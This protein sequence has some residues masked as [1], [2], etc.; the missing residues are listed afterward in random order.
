MLYSM[1]TNVIS[2]FVL[3]VSITLFGMRGLFLYSR[4]KTPLI[5]YFGLGAILGGISALMYSVPF[6]FTHVEST[7]KITTII[8]DFFYYAAIIVMTRLI[9]Y[10]GF[11]KKVNYLWVLIPYLITIAGAFISSIYY[12]PSINYVFSDGSVT[13]PVPMV[14]SWFFA[15][16]SSAFVFVGLLT[17]F[18]ARHITVATQRV[19]LYLIGS[20]FLVGGVL[21][22][23]NFLFSH[24]S[25]TSLF[26]I[27]GY[28]IV[29]LTLFVGI[30]IISRNKS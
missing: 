24:G 6:V 25:N 18:S 29:A 16:M 15:A 19:R 11:N 17:I 30:F 4:Q 14:A 8:G 21:A 20:A 9:W 23:I 10:L 28:V 12:L 27:A 1:P 2:F 26:G 22:I 7:L 3:G 5:L 13:Y